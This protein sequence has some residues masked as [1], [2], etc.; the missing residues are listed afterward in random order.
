MYQSVN[1]K[2]FHSIFCFI[3]HFKRELKIY[4]TYLVRYGTNPDFYYGQIE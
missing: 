1:L 4:N 3:S 2:K